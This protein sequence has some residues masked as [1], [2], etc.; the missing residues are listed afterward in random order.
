L[1]DGEEVVIRLRPHARVLAR[2]L[3]VLLGA[4]ALGGF[5]AGRVP[6]G[7]WQGPGRW[8]VAAV[9]AAVVVRFCLLPWLRW[10]STTYLVTER[11]VTL[12]RGVLRR[13]SRGVPLSRVADVGVERTLGQRLF[14]S[15]T[16]V[17]DTVGE[18][19]GLVLRD[20]PAVRDVAEQLN[21]L[22]DLVP[23]DEG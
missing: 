2:P 3:L 16:L 20:V 6:E 10:L 18:R 12:E 14:G 7:S 5:G 9:T 15:G 23:L 13:S 1:P 19:G 22:L 11:R 8:A 4:L 21:E 17:L